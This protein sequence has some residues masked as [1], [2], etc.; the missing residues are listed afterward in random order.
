VTAAT[1]PESPNAVQIRMLPGTVHLI[2]RVGLELKLATFESADP[3]V[4]ARHT[5]VM[6]IT[7]Q[8]LSTDFCGKRWRCRFPVQVV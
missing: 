4:H 5:K 3:F 1:F 2:Q 7:G 6:S 8:A